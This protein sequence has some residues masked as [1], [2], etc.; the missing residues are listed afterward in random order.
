[1]TSTA[2]APTNP[3]KPAAFEQAE[4]LVRS[5][6]EHLGGEAF[7][8]LINWLAK[9]LDREQYARLEQA[10]DNSSNRIAL[11]QVFVDLNVSP[12]PVEETGND[13]SSASGFPFLKYL[14]LSASTRRE[15]PMGR[16]RVSATSNDVRDLD[17]V[18]SPMNGVVLIGGPG[19][20]KSTLGQLLCQLHRAWILAPFVGDLAK[21][22]EKKAVEAFTNEDARKDLGL[23]AEIAFPIRIVLPD[24]AA[25]LAERPSN[26]PNGD[27]PGLLHFVAAKAKER[28]LQIEASHFAWL[29]GTLQRVLPCYLRARNGALERRVE[30]AS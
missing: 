7:V 11:A 22:S 10:G 12:T 4:S 1:M 20:G 8:T 3:P 6:Q 24:A 19:Q 5:I 27:V 13:A 17:V 30:V 15:R 23:P 25:W 26:T 14:C 18:A 21:E 2:A 9:E 28:S 29:A 16:R